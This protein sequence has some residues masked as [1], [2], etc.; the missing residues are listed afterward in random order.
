MLD[1]PLHFPSKKRLSWGFLIFIVLLL[2]GYFVTHFSEV[3]LN[4]SGYVHLLSMAFLFAYLILV[5]LVR[6]FQFSQTIKYLTFWLGIILTILGIYSFRHRLVEVLNIIEEKVL[7]FKDPEIQPGLMKF[8]SNNKGH[9]M[10][11]A[12]VE[13]VPI[14]FKLDTE[15]TLVILTQMDARRLGLTV[16]ELAYTHPT[17]TTDGLVWSAPIRLQKIKVGEASVSNIAASISKDDLAQSLL[18]MSFLKKIKDYK[19]HK[20]VLILKN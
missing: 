20:D 10:I 1:T 14:K 17:N 19:I 15:A 18:G 16:N 8:P 9:F 6:Y 13:G 7:P 3:S 2:A 11:E 12:I 4:Q 5:L